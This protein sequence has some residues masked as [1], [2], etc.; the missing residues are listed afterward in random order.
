[1]L[2]W[3]YKRLAENILKNI[4]FEKVFLELSSNENIQKQVLAMT[5]QL[6]DR[7]KKMA[8]GALGGMQK[9]V[10]YADGGNIPS[11]IDS[12][13]HLSLK[14]LIPVLLP[15]LLGNQTEKQSTLP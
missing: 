8:I 14:G 7:Y 3:A 4:D 6:Y 5:D 15:R 11:I 12:R 9:G 10:N 1:L 2:G 13:G